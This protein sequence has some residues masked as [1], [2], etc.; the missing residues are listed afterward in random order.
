MNTSSQNTPSHNTQQRL[1]PFLAVLALLAIFCLVPGAGAQSPVDQLATLEIELWP[2]Y[3]QP[4]VLVLLTGT[5]GD[6]AATPATVTLPIPTA[7]TI[8]AV[9][10]VNAGSGDMENVSDVNSDTP[11]EL[12][13]TTPSPTFRIEYY[14]PYNSDGDRHDFTFGWRSDMTIDQLLATVQQP[15][16]AS[17]FQLS[18]AAAQTRIGADG[19]TYHA[20]DAQALPA[21]QEFSV[22]ASYDLAGGELSADVVPT[23]Q[24]QVQGPLPLVSEPAQPADTGLNW[25][26]VAIIAGGLIIVAAVVWFLFSSNTTRRKRT[27]RPRPVRHAK[28][29]G[30]RPSATPSAAQFCHNCGQPIDD[31]D[32]FCRNCGTPVKGR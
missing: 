30:S 29:R 14:L 1:S 21:G 2:D 16:G 17:D 6:S 25:A 26:L 23:L 5:L 12:T 15:A 31:E 13:F 32:R 9:A 28:P 8:N 19:L 18:P 20:F 22:T 10:H 7:A 27:P 11:G 3:D 4:Q 24:P